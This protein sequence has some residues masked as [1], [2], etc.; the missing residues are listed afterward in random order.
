MLNRLNG[1]LISRHFNRNQELLNQLQGKGR[2]DAVFSGLVFFKV[3]ASAS[4]LF[5]I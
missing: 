4:W 1:I 3:K 5:Y 2:S